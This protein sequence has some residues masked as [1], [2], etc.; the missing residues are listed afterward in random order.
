MESKQN[1]YAL[2]VAMMFALFFS[3]AFVT[4]LPSPIGVIIA[5]QFDASVFESKLGV[6]ANFSAYGFRGIPAGKRTRLQAG[7]P[8]KA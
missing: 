5:R 7:T 3:I 1:R 4:G 8:M 2:P 6:F